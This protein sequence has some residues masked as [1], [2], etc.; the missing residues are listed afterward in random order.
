MIPRKNTSHPTRESDN[1]PFL[2]TKHNFFQNGYSPAAIEE[3]IR[4]DTDI[5]KSDS[6]SILKKTYPKLHTTVIK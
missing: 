4:L 6:I 1:I 2:R 3:W 5:R